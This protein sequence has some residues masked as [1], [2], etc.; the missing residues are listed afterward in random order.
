MTDAEALRGQQ[1]L[2]TTTLDQY[3]RVRTLTGVAPREKKKR[4]ELKLA[5]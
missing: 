3:N 2:G 4:E 5:A 1:A